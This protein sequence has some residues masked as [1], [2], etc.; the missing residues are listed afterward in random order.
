[1]EKNEEQS[2]G[3]ALRKID[4]IESILNS[5]KPDQSNPASFQFGINLEHRFVID[6]KLLIIIMDIE[7]LDEDYKCGSIKTG[8]TFELTEFDDYLS[9]DQKAINL[10]KDLTIMLNSIAISTTRGVMFAH[11]RG[12]H[13]HNAILPIIDPS[14]MQKRD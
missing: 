11:L 14:Q 12:T 1:M 2:F 7:M 8:C 4:I 6:K 9:E 3:F 10:P 5:P 13:L